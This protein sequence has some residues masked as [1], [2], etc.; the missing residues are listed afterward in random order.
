MLVMF[1]ADTKA[2]GLQNSFVEEKLHRVLGVASGEMLIDPKCINFGNEL[3]LH[4]FVGKE[5][6]QETGVLL[7]QNLQ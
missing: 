7:F 2:L 6:T 1:E 3:G 4:G 5:S